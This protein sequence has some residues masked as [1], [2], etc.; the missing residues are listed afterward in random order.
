MKKS[1]FNHLTFSTHAEFSE[2]LSKH[3]HQTILLEDKGQDIQKIIIHETG[4]ILDCDFCSG[5]YNGKF[6]NL[7]KIKAGEPIELWNDTKSDWDI[8][9]GL[10]TEHVTSLKP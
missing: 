1:Q 9:G 4:E 7:E 8:M 3:K 5:L 6:V 2:W 10:V